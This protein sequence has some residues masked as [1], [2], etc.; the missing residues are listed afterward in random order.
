M[1]NKAISKIFKL[2]SQLMELHNENPF[3]TK[4]M[5]SASF[6]LDKLPFRIDD[7]SLEELSAQPGI[8]KSTAEKAKE[9]AQTGTFKELQ[10]LLANTPSGVVE[11]LNIKGLGLK[12]FRLSGKTLVLKV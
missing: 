2:C 8:G 3:R 9:V 5:A 10:D 11:M 7:A 12:R 6:K 4:A 1:D